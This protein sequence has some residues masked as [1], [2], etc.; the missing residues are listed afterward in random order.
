MADSNLELAVRI[1][2][3]LRKSLQNLG[4]LEKGYR[5]GIAQEK[6]DFPRHGSKGGVWRGKSLLDYHAEIGD[7]V[8][9]FV[10]CGGGFR[11]GGWT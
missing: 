2:T 10:D 11:R 3:D 8:A 7:A 5:G 1:R 9:V 4:R 6:R